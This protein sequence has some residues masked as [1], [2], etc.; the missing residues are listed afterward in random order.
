MRAP[1][2]PDSQTECCICANRSPAFPEVHDVACQ[3]ARFIAEYV[4]HP[5]EILVQLAR[6]H[7]LFF[8]TKQNKTVQ[9]KHTSENGGKL[10]A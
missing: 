10:G 1:N 3:G 4:L 6:P 5:P 8:E 9:S 2:T 7:L